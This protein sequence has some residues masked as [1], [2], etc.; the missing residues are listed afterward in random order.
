MLKDS[1]CVLYVFERT[2]LQLHIYHHLQKHG[3]LDDQFN[4]WMHMKTVQVY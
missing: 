2:K 3:I 4:E 1:V